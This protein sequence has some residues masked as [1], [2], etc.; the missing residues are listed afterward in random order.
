MGW[1]TE[2]IGFRFLREARDFSVLHGVHSASGSHLN[3]YS[4]ITGSKAIKLTTHLHLVQRLGIREAM[5]PLRHTSSWCE[6]IYVYPHIQNYEVIRSKAIP[7][8][9]VE[10]HMD[11][12]RRGSH[13]FQTMGWQMA[14]RLSASRGGRPGFLYPQE[15]SWYS[16]L[17]EAERPQGHSE[18]GSIGSI[19]KIQWPH[20]ESNPRP[21]VRDWYI[22]VS[23]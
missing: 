19:E 12:R 6:Q 15:D 9:A 1:I 5:P 20:R 16:F 18:A 23:F 14:V 13:I 3:P 4:I 2:R 22:I 17:S 10:V 7:V 11:V 8:K 21:S